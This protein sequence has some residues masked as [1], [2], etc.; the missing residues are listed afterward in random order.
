MI[1]LNNFVWSFKPLTLPFKAK[2]L[3]FTSPDLTLQ[4]STFCPQG[5]LHTI[6][7]IS[8][9]YFPV[10]I[11]IVRFCTEAV[12]VYCES[13]TQILK[14]YNIKSILLSSSHSTLMRVNDNYVTVVKFNVWSILF[15]NIFEHCHVQYILKIIY[16][17]KKSLYSHLIIYSCKNLNDMR[18]VYVKKM[19]IRNLQIQ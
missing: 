14:V 19:H 9:I 13:K 12:N 8:N 18:S 6:L 2:W 10:Q 16:A 17:K 15:Y 3:A 1:F 5:V 4:N 7:K 11:H